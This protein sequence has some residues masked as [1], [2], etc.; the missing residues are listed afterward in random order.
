MRL[1][2]PYPDACHCWNW[3]RKAQWWPSFRERMLASRGGSC[4]AVLKVVGGPGRTVLD[5]TC[6]LGRE[7]LILQDLGLT[8]AGSDAS[9]YAVE[10]TRELAASEQRDI[11][12]FVSP[13]SD[14][15]ARTPLRFDAVFV[16]AFVDCCQ[17]RE[18]LAAAFAGIAG[19]L[20][21]GGAFIYA[22]PDHGERM[23]DI[24]QQAWTACAAFYLDWRF[25]TE[26]VTCTC[27]HARERG[28]DFI[29]D[30]H[31]HVIDSPDGGQRLETAT[32]RQWFRWDRDCLD[33]L[34]RCAGFG[35]ISTETFS[36]Y[37][38]GGT[39]FTRIVA[40]KRP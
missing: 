35:Q 27:L 30:H 11:E 15:P 28:S 16:D 3:F 25:A 12:C 31:L 24:H 17:T 13:W 29:D 7:T 33:N 23:T 18:H 1:A 5:A 4:G 10:K 34:A 22:G 38:F 6:G 32:I 14:L 20:K 9:A 2:E 19:V 26:Q 36:G 8:V 40:R 21:N 39:S 37:G